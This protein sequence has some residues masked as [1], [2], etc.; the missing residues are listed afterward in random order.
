MSELGYVTKTPDKVVG[1]HFFNPAHVMKRIE[2]IPVL[3]TSDETVD[4]VVAFSESLRK[5]PVRVNECAGFL[6]NRILM[7]YI[8]EAF[9]TLQENAASAKEIDKAMVSFGMPMGPFT[10]VDM[11]GLD[12]AD[13]VADL[14]YNSYGERMKSAALRT[15]IQA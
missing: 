8:N 6:V 10:L 14:L 2:V 4:D 12:V 1:M 11:L 9:Y 7:S 13:S 5:I 3:Q 15:T